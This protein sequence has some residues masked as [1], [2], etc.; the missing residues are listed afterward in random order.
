M[1]RHLKPHHHA[2]ALRASS[3]AIATPD[4]PNMRLM[5]KRPTGPEDSTPGPEITL[6]RD[7]FDALEGFVPKKHQAVRL[8]DRGAACIEAELLDP[9]GNITKARLL[10]P[11]S[12]RNSQRS[13]RRWLRERRSATEQS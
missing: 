13:L 3:R 1:A 11:V 12:A 7:Q 5:P 9:D 8:R 6:T 2:A 10:W 4:R